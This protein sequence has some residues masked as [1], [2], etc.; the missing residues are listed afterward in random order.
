M[1]PYSI[2]LHI[3][4][5]RHRCSYC[6]FNTY[7]GIDDLIPAYIRG[8]RHEIRYLAEIW[9]TKPPIKTIF[10]GG[11]TP[12][13]LPV[14]GIEKVI[15]EL[16]RGFNLLEEIE[17]TIEANPG[18]LS[19]DYLKALY[20]LGINRISLGMQSANSDELLL[21]ER[22]H[23]AHQ[24][25]NA[26]RYAKKAGFKNVN[27]DLIFGIPH[28]TLESWQ[29]SLELGLSLEPEHFSLYSLIIEPDTLMETWISKGLQP[30]PDEDLSAD[31][32]ELASELLKEHGYEQYEISNWARRDE[33]NVL[34]AC[35]HNLQYWR[36]QPYVGLGAGSHGYIA[37]K[38]TVNIQTPI[39]YIQKMLTWNAHKKQERLEFPATPVTES[40][41]T[42]EKSEEIKET[43]MMGLRLTE[44]GV[45]EKDFLSRFDTDLKDFYGK[46]INELI[47]VGLLEWDRTNNGHIRL[48]PRGR[49]LG[50]QV[51]QQFI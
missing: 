44:E 22:Q 27:L 46:Q 41:V 31:M 15:D 38:R 5:C 12:S 28:Q 11:G 6:D 17:F 23:E 2:Y 39:E 1:Q 42:I 25:A 51:F 34:L 26:V 37:G 9:E 14:S 32:Y 21:L 19:Y 36:N 4:F 33:N 8:L 40:V 18:Q 3:P 48:T 16:Y 20:E 24:T 7:A 29:L 49:L 43:M 45:S 13:I 50:N 30:K 10:L 35:Q 47:E